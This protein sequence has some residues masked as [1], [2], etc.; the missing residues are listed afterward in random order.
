MR[1]V[2]T[3]TLS[4]VA[5]SCSRNSA[6]AVSCDFLQW[7]VICWG[8]WC[9]GAWDRMPCKSNPKPWFGSEAWRGADCRLWGPRIAELLTN[10]M[11][12]FRSCLKVLLFE[13]YVLFF[14]LGAV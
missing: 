1:L 8:I 2:Q 7:V 4:F 13:R 10:L 5:E 6:L 12:P 3:T 11:V 14:E 9:A